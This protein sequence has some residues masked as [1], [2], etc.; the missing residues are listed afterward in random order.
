[1]S[2]VTMPPRLSETDLSTL[3][4]FE[5]QAARRDRLM[6]L[7]REHC[8]EWFSPDGLFTAT[9]AADPRWYLWCAMSMLGGEPRHVAK[10]N[11]VLRQ[12]TPLGGGHFWTS[13][14]AS[15]LA[16]WQ[17]QLEP[18]V[19]QAMIR[20]LR[21]LLPG[22]RPQR[23]RG[24]N[25]NFP[26]MSTVALL[27]GAPLAGEDSLI[28]DG[29]KCLDSLRKLLGRRG[30]LS[31][32]TSPTY[33]PITLTCLAEVAELSPSAE[34]RELALW[35][36]QRVWLDLCSHF[37]PGT[38]ALAGPHSRAYMVDLC[39]HLHN[40]HMVL[41]L[42]FGDVVFVNPAN[43]LFPYQ[44]GQVTHNG[45]WHIRGHLPWHLVPTYHVSEPAARLVLERR[46]PLTVQAT[47]EQAAMQ[48]NVWEHVRHPQTPLAEIPASSMSLTSYLTDDYALGV[49]ERPFLDGYQMSVFHLVYR[50]RRPARR[51]GEVAAL[52][53]R[54]LTT[55]TD[56]HRHRQLYDQGR[57]N[58]V[59]HE[60][61]AMVAYKARCGWGSHPQPGDVT[62]E[63]TTSLRLSL[64][65]TCFESGPEEAWLGDQRLEDWRGQSV[66]PVS[67]FWRDGPM[68]IAVHP[69]NLYDHGRT[70]AVALRQVN[71][72][73]LIDLFNYQGPPRTFAAH[74]LLTT[75]NGF[76]IEVATVDQWS[77]LADFRRHHARP[78]IHDTYHPGDCIRKLSYQREGLSL[79]MA[80]S[81]VSEGIQYRTINDQLAP[82]HK[83]R[84]ESASG[85][86]EVD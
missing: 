29:M 86:L 35:C 74:D 53:P 2:A 1:M 16:R 14:A 7:H 60:G 23:F 45:D 27:V 44:P 17:D 20:R 84:I 51:L 8:E 63:P 15:I 46:H 5:A 55:L 33:T 61:T 71:G 4:G 22:E 56:P 24:Y 26:A 10:A 67:V 73:H 62:V 48:R 36:E 66:E 59:A 39:A 42:V 68:L 43:A 81:P 70:H 40:A 65:L 11:A 64:L 75:H 12:G 18:D 78:R 69:L 6:A 72:Y 57:A 28:A 52:F 79:G 34:A 32:Y 30:L 37:H 19:R 31:E 77:S 21:E 47:S 85:R 82:L 76:V 83:L 38:S 25:D 13:A 41:H 9:A 80:L 54:Y 49:S 3:I 58:A 50:R